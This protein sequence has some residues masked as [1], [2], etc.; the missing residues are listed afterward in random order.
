MTKRQHLLLAGAALVLV[1]HPFGQLASATDLDDALA[2]AYGTNPTIDAERAQVRATDENVPQALSGWR[3]TVKATAQASQNW[4]NERKPLNSSSDF[5]PRSYGLTVTQPIFRGLRTVKGTSQAENQVQAERQRL[6]STEQDT[7]FRAV[8]AYMG[9]VRDQS[10]LELNQNNVKVLQAQLASTQDQFQVGEL[11]R[12]DVAQA[13]SSLQGAIAAQ[14]QAEGN[15][16][17]SRATYREVIGAEP[18]D[19]KMPTPHLQLP[20]TKDESVAQAQTVPTVGAAKFEQKAA[21]DQIDVTFGQM[22]PEVS[23]EGSFQRNDNQNFGQSSFNEGIILG[24]VTI[25]LY[26][27]GNVESQ[28]RQSKQQYY[29]SKALVDEALRSAEQQAVAAWQTLDTANAQIS[30]FEEQVKSARVAL[31]GIRQEQQVGARTII[32]VLDQ[33]QSYLN[34][35]VSLVG[36]QTDQVVAQYQLLASVGRLTARELKLKTDL[37]DPTKHYNAVR[38]K[39]FGTGPSV[40]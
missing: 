20:A 6:T 19:L 23:I 8:Q 24:L 32:D 11:T 21:K 13:K 12:T 1:V 39:F 9:V 38:N 3:P 14:I 27:A 22:L 7:L 18:V 17:T 37:Y 15:L 25:P 33:E 4:V 34:A 31:D 30:A 36:A 29:R 5:S 16:K 35:Q 2:L 10:V 40:E 28:V 26:Q